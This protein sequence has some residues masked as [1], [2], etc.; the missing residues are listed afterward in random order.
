[1]PNSPLDLALRELLDRYPTQVRPR[2]PPLN[3]RNAGGMSGS[4][5]WRFDTDIGPL[6]A[7]A[8][9]P[10]IVDPAP[11]ERTQ[12]WLAS[13]SDLPFIPSAIPSADGSKLISIRGRF[14]EITPWLTG[15]PDLGTSPERDHV[16]AAFRALAIVHERLKHQPDAS[17]GPSPGLGRRLN[18]LDHWIG[19]GFNR[20]EVVLLA[21]PSEPRRELALR[22]LRLAR[23]VAP[24]IRNM[25]ETAS[26]TVLTLQPCIRDTRRDH[27]LFQDGELSG[28]VDFGAMGVD[29]VV[30]DLSRLMIDWFE[31][32]AGLELE[33]QAM[34]AYEEIRTIGQAERRLMRVFKES[35][36]FL[37]PGHWV[38]WHFVEGRD[39]EDPDAVHRGL[40]RGVERF[41]RL[42]GKSNLPWSS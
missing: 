41:E 8:W 13:I 42:I 32:I 27:F 40:N 6:L 22:W 31:E 9:P 17:T 34:A 37:G 2:T 33:A 21:N 10:E 4:N 30:G 36:L 12:R 23:S 3:L 16:R 14:W 5:L 11:L 24:Q 39:F 38:R 7:R 26:R 1:M 20:I 19:G 15:S 28:L 25:L 29:C 18:E 35:A